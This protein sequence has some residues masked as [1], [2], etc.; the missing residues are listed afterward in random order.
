[1]KTGGLADM[2]AGLSGALVDLGE[3]VTVATPLYREVREHISGIKKQ[4][5]P[6]IIIPLGKN[7]FSGRWW[8]VEAESGVT[9]L[10]LE[11]EDFYDRDGLYMQGNDGYWDNPERFMF[12]SKAV[13]R[14]SPEYDVVHVHDWQTA[15][16]PML[17]KSGMKRSQPQTILTIHNLAYQGQCGGDR[18]SITNLPAKLFQREGPEFWGNMNFLKAGISFADGITTVSPKYAR[19][20][21]TQE[22][23]EGLDGVLRKRE[24]SLSGILNGVDYKEWNTENNPDLPA[25]YSANDLSGKEKCKKALQEELGLPMLDAPLFGSITRLAEQKGIDVMIQA[26]DEIL[27]ENDMQVVILGSGEDHFIHRLNKLQEKYNNC[28]MFIEGYNSR[29]AHLIEAGADFFLMPSRFEP[30]GLNQLYSLRYGTLPIVHGVG[31]LDDTIENLENDNGNGF[32]F[33]G[34]SKD[35]LSL[36]IKRAFDFYSNKNTMQLARQNA[37]GSQ[38]SWDEPAQSYRQLY[39]SSN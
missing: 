8:K 37:M 36:A 35:N 1:S 33:Y 11:N 13:A 19:E 4:Y 27:C 32:K 7:K 16:V 34:L 21:L 6:E 23:G 31:G 26:L 22:F 12:L 25:S 2:V 5:G 30:C 14:L 38:H 9:M 28:V 39:Y 17:L 24:D 15:F 29:L 10:F 18:F 20:I 3:E